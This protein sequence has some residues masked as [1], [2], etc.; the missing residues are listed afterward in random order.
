MIC[1]LYILTLYSVYLSIRLLP[2]LTDNRYRTERKLRGKSTS[3]KVAKHGMLHHFVTSYRSCQC[4]RCQVGRSYQSSVLL[5]VWED[6]IGERL[7]RRNRQCQRPLLLD[8]AGYLEPRD[9]DMQYWPN[10]MQFRYPASA[11]STFASPC[12][13]SNVVISSAPHR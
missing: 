11:S 7:H 2:A 6:M 12:S 8:R 10:F 9:A 5:R 13:F 1:Q 3:C 4:P